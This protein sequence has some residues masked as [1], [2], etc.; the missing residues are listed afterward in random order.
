MSS[1]NN[2]FP[3]G[4]GSPNPWPAAPP[5]WGGPPQPQQPWPSAQGQ[6]S[7][8][9][10]PFSP[11][12]PSQ[13][14]GGPFAPTP[15]QTPVDDRP[16]DLGEVEVAWPL[17]GLPNTCACCN[18][19]AETRKTT[20]A[21]AQVGRTTERRSVEIPYCRR[22]LQHLDDGNRR[23][24][25]LGVV[26]TLMAFPAPVLLMLAWVYVPW[27]VAIPLGAVVS[28]VVLAVT[29]RLWKRVP[30]ARAQGCCGSDQPATWMSGF[31]FGAPSVRFRGVNPQWMQ[32]LATGSGAQL[33]P[34][35]VRKAARGR[36]IAAPLVVLL[37]AIPMWFAMH[38]RVYVDNP[39][40]VALTF[41]FDDG[42][43][44]ITVPAG[45][46]DDLRIPSGDT[47]VFVKNGTQ[48]VETI[49]GSVGHWSAHAI[50][51]LGYACYAEIVSVYG[52]AVV[53][54]P[55]YVRAP[56]GER[57]HDLDGV[58]HVFEA[59]PSSVSAGRGQRG[60]T[61]KRFQRINC[62]TGAPL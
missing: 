2:G 33:R 49:R 3:P 40:T 60:A 47:R 57:W 30:V 42:S 54:G 22:C 16:E 28:L 8:P 21:A 35:G 24:I 17:R 43:A 5:A 19:P 14:S 29:E 53:T 34:A 26:A 25:V 56:P 41:D 51:P 4:A 10:A 13:Q 62:V 11:Q 37:A 23:G 39:S 15:V 61:R 27:F 1:N 31:T 9:Y 32:Q 7:A 50:T 48:T 6:P 58:Q 38:G 44:E 59:A 52:S 46:H 36:W 55:G 18:A 20:T 45:G 12:S